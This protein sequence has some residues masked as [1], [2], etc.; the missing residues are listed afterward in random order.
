MGDRDARRALV[1]HLG[2]VRALH[3][4]LGVVE[5]VEVAGRQRRDRLGAD[6]HPGELDDLEHLRDAVVHL[7]DE[8]ADGGLALAE[9]QLAG[10]R[11]LE[12]HLVLDVGDLYAVALAELAGL[13]VEVELGN[14]EQAQALGAGAGAFRPGEH[15]VNDVVGHVVL[16]AGDEALDALDVPRAVGLLGGLRASGPDVGSGVGLGQ[17]HRGA[18]PVLDHLLGDLALLLGA[19]A[20]DDVGEARPGGVHVDGRVGA[21][22]QLGD[23]PLEAERGHDAAELG[24]QVKAPPLGV[25]V[26]LEGLLEALRHGHGAGGRV[27]DGRVAVGVE[28]RVGELVARQAL[29]LGEDAAGRVGVDLVEGRL[30]EQ[31][32][33]AEDL[34]EVELD[35]AQVALVVTHGAVLPC[36]G[37]TGQMSLLPVSNIIMLLTSNL[38]N[39]FGH[40]G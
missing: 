25:H 24:G 32:L 14:D 4:G 27:E 33:A 7:A 1:R 21:E 36:G 40:L 13:P 15:E 10:G 23:G 6:H 26:G 5:R 37:F 19:E 3:A 22:H 18:P 17:H 16:G 9:G 39:R 28:Q 2:Q 29:D 30:A 8:P 12:A 38:C 31:L 11:G 20:V 34:E 35:V